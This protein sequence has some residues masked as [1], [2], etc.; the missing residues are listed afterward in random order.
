MSEQSPQENSQPHT[1]QQHER[2][3]E[4]RILNLLD[5]ETDNEPKEEQQAEPE[6]KAE[7]ESKDQPQEEKAESEDKNDQK[8]PDLTEEI[9]Y[10]GEKF[11]I[12]AKLKDGFL[13]QQDY[14]RKTQEVAEKAKATEALMQQIQKQG[15]LQKAQVKILGKIEA[16]DEQI[17]Q[18]EKVDWN[19][20]VAQ[21]SILAQRHH[22]QFQSLKDQKAKAQGELKAAEDQFTA[23]AN[24]VKMARLEEG[25]K[26]LQ[27]DI[28]GWGPELAQKLIQFAVH[29]L[30]WSAE[31]A[32]SVTDPG[33]V[34]AVHGAYELHQL[35]TQKPAEKKVPAPNQTLKPQGSEARNPNQQAYEQDR[36][37]LKSAKTV[38]EQMKAAERLIARKFG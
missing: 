36:R 30:G 26:V 37:A 16:L 33:V 31:A 8:L 11:K 29:N 23:E 2:A 6:A 17:A 12:P 38:S 4:E 35:R 24:K 27:R 7:G 10:E 1:P 19:A 20:L 22:I 21:D 15:E 34:K 13:R 3:I 28:K 32:S 18:Y 9:E 5:P 25:Y 14:T